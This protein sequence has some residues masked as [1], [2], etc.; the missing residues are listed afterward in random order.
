MAEGWDGCVSKRRK[1][2]DDCELLGGR[3]GED[4]EVGAANDVV[5]GDWGWFEVKVAAGVLRF[6]G[7]IGVRRRSGGGR[8]VLLRRHC[9]WGIRV[10]K[11]YGEGRKDRG[12]VNEQGV[13]GR[14]GKFF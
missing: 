14:G 9:G 2:R 11:G 8:G 1:G 3:V 12:I 5:E 7:G 4:A 10:G 13:V 6:E